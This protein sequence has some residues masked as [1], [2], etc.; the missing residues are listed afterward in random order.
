FF[1][2]VFA[3][4][5]AARRRPPW[6]IAPC[7]ALVSYGWTFQM[8]FFNYYLSLGL[9]FFGLAILWR[10]KGWER[11]IGLAVA[12]LVLLAHPLGL[13]WL[14]GAGAYVVVAERVGFRYQIVLLLAA[15]A[16]LAGIHEYLWHHYVVEPQGLGEHSFY[17]FN[18]ADQLILFSR[19]YD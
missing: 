5:S 14:V 10:G 16:V 6:H 8:G 9:S 3:L 18:G 17:F 2:G 12:P 7:I 1:W 19:R 13:F 11:L 15:A 4:V